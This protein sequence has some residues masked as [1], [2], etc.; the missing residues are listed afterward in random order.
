MFISV[1]NIPLAQQEFPTSCWISAAHFLLQY[2]GVNVTL[3][4]LHAR[5]Y[6]PALNNVMAMNGAG[7]PVSILGEYAFDAGYAPKS[8][9]HSQANEVEL[10][11]AVANCIRWGFRSKMNAIPG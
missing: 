5:Y 9:V 1:R 3:R 11:Q 4:V 10:L 7:N 6:N 2:V 8:M